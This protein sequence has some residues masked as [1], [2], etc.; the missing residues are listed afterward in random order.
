M[1]ISSLKTKLCKGFWATN[2]TSV[3]K[4]LSAHSQHYLYLF[5]KYHAGVKFVFT[6]P[7][8]NRL[9]QRRI[10]DLYKIGSYPLF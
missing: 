8:N 7:W 3:S 1:N 10:K 5:Y 2:S 4:D 6:K 9:W